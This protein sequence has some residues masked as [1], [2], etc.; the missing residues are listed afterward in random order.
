MFDDIQLNPERVPL[1]KLILH[2]TQIVLSFVAWCLEIVVFR[3]KNS[4]INGQSGWAFGVC[5]LSIPVWIYLIGAP[6]FP[7]TRRIAEPHAM[8]VVDALA[9]VLWLSAFAAQAAF[10][11]SDRC[12]DGCG[13]SKAIVALG[14]FNTLLFC[15]TTF[16]SVY[17]LKYYQFN[18][19]LP[20]YDR[21]GSTQKLSQNNIDPD[22][23]AFST[24]PHDDE[25]YAHINDM[26]DYEQHDG[27][28][29]RSDVSGSGVGGYGGSG[30]GY[31]HAGSHVNSSYF[32][33]GAGGSVAGSSTAYGGANPFD[34][35]HASSSIGG[36]RPAASHSSLGT[37]TAPSGYAPPT[38]HD[39]FDED[40]PVRFPEADYDRH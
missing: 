11:S 20:G 37:S 29:Y 3:A 7:R 36:L 19:S 32:D 16:Y 31:A 15:A 30:S 14:V 13:P 17:S 2:V 26:D 24:A 12:G 8:L 40:Q 1:Y 6:R 9:V 10:N 33:T 5:F 18:G 38:V 27:H 28:D 39:A 25:P 23:A 34:D 21:L 22:M 35:G 4:H